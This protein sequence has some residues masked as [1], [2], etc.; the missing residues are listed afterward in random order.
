MDEEPGGQDRCSRLGLVA[1]CDEDHEGAAEEVQ[2]HL[3][4][5]P[6][7]AELRHEHEDE[8]DPSDELEVFL[9]LVLA[10]MRD[11]V[12]KGSGLSARLG[13]DE[14]ESSDDSEI[15]A[16]KLKVPVTVGHS[17]EANVEDEQAA[18]DPDAGTEENHSGGTELS[19]KVDDDEEGGQVPA[20][21]P[22]LVHVLALLRPLDPHSNPV[23]EEGGENAKQGQV[24]KGDLVADTLSLGDRFVV[25]VCNKRTSGKQRRTLGN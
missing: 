18:A 11:S 13:E 17:L 8:Q 15:R 3:K 21:A 5:R 10:Q 9:R 25:L 2:Q 12:E 16:E 20:A 6:L 4:S 22:G 14:K 23:L 19:E 24:R 7:E 1:D